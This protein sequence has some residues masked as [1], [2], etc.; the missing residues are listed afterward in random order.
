MKEL[1]R[2]MEFIHRSNEP[3]VMP[4][5]TFEMLSQIAERKFRGG[6]GILRPLV[7]AEEVRLLSIRQ[8]SLDERERAEVESHVD[9][10]YHFLKQ[11]PWTREIRNIPEI[12]RG[13][14]EK[15][16]GRGYPG[17]LDAEEI[18]LQTR[19][20]SVADVFDALAAS[21]R[22]YKPSV[23]IER[24]LEILAQMAGDGE[25]DPQVYEL[26]VQA[27]VCERWKLECFEY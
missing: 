18:P 14:H 20:M 10:T 13:H 27:K 26:F 21:D 17:K 22:P 19:L 11:I 12:A 15:L 9:H 6:D 1:D 25:I 5:G 8:G 23:S 2:F 24:A 4:A 3:S 16:N 7:T